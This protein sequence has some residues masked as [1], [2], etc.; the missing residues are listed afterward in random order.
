M[1]VVTDI[2]GT[3]LTSVANPCGY[4]KAIESQPGAV[5]QCIEGWRRLGSE[6]DLEP[7]FIPAHLGF[8]CARTF[9]RVGNELAGMVIVGGVT[10]PSGPLDRDSLET[11]ATESGIPLDLLAEHA[12]ETYD[13]GPAQQEW[14]LKMLPRISDMISRLASAR[15]QLLRKLDAVADLTGAAFEE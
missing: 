10:H 5:D 7:R 11:I 9:I 1:A 13:L 14:V 15:S 4:F 3:A 6:P 2:E 12:D 8:L